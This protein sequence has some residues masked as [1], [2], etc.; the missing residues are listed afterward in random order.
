MYRKCAGKGK[1]ERVVDI[2]EEKGRGEAPISVVELSAEGYHTKEREEGMK[3]Q[4]TLGNRRK[5]NGKTEWGRRLN[6]ERKRRLLT[7][8]GGKKKAFP[9]FSKWATKRSL[10][11]I[12]PLE[13]VPDSGGRKG[14]G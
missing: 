11:E 6:P 2:W 3:R 12:D 1:G 14:H 8:M 4:R 5:R 9:T 10:Q 7:V 13:R